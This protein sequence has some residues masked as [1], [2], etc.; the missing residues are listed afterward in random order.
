MFG[1]SEHS[2]RDRT[3]SVLP[4]NTYMKRQA[5]LHVLLRWVFRHATRSLTCAL[6]ANDG[7][8]DVCVLPHW[9]LDAATLES[10]DDAGRAFGRHAQIAMMLRS[11]GW[12]LIDHAGATTGGQS[13]VHV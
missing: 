8:F 2:D 7:A 10:F 12:K 6:I 1:K 4:C 9:D 11:D 13:H 5:E 3:A